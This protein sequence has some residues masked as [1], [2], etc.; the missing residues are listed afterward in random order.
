METKMEILYHK[1]CRDCGNEM[2]V[3]GE[4]K[5]H[6]KASD[7][8]AEGCSMFGE[9]GIQC[10][11]CFRKYRMINRGAWHRLMMQEMQDQKGAQT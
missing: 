3:T 2:L 7:I 5:I 10:D 11:E 4:I 8:R 1:F 6:E 9:A